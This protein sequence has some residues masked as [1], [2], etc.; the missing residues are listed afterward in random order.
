MFF[1]LLFIL[2]A[3]VVIQ[4]KWR[5][6]SIELKRKIETFIWQTFL[7]HQTDGLFQL[8]LSLI[9]LLPLLKRKNHL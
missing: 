7:N 4:T 2:C 3:V 8:F 5:Y 9:N 6:K 1:L